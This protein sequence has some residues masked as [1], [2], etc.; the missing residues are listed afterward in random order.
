MRNVFGETQERVANR[1]ERREHNERGE[2]PGEVRLP[3]HDPETTA[4]NGID[5]QTEKA[6]RHAIDDLMLLTETKGRYTNDGDPK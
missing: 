1:G 4:E 5:Q 2:Q 3:G 6:L